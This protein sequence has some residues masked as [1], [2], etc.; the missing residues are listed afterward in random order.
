[1]PK[2]TFIVVLLALWFLPRTTLNA[3]DFTAEFEGP[4][5]S[6][7]V[8]LRAQDASLAIHQRRR[9]A[10]REGG[11]EVIRVNS[12]KENTPVRI[13]HPLPPATVLDELEVAVWVKSDREGFSLALKVILPEF[14][15][16]ET[17]APCTLIIVGDQYRTPGQWQQL[18]C[19]TK[20]RAVREQLQLKRALKQITRDPREMYVDQVILG[21][22]LPPGPTDVALDDL[23]VR[24]FVAYEKTLKATDPE[25]IQ[26]AGKSTDNPR[27]AVAAARIPV[28]FR[29]HRLSVEDRPFFPRMITYQN[30]RPEVLA[31]AGA[32]VVWVP[33]FEDSVVTGQLR[34]QGLWV[35]AA[36]PYAKGADGEALDSED[37]SLLPFGTNTSSVLFWM[38]GARMKLDGPPKL[39]S[40][41]NQIRD[42]DRGVRRPIAADVIE[43]ERLVSRH[44]DMLGVSRHVIHSIC[45]L[46]DYRDW[47][48]QRRE[49]A[50]PD[51]FCFTWIQTEPAPQVSDLARGVRTR[52]MLEPEQ[53]RLQ[54]YAALGAGCR[55]LGFWTT[56]PLD[57]D[58]PAARERLLALS[59]LNLELQLFE[60]WIASGG[61]PELVTFAIDTPRQQYSIGVRGIRPVTPPASPASR[62]RNAKILAA[63]QSRELKAAMIGSDRGALLLPMWLEE[64]SQFV[65]GPLAARNMSII[66]PG[67]GETAAAWEITTTGRL[68]N[69]NREPAAGGVKI[70]LP[71][72]DQTAAILLTSD[73]QLVAEL[74]EQI[75][76]IQDR[77]AYLCVELAK[78]K[79]AR[80]LEIDQTL[81]GMGVG[82]PEAPQLISDARQ[83]LDKAE[84]AMQAGNYFEAQ[85]HASE[86]LQFARLLQRNHWEY[87]IQ[88][89][90]N[91]TSSPWAVSFQSLP[92][93]WSLMRRIGQ[94]GSLDSEENLLPSGEFEDIKTLIG[95][96]WKHE[97]SML[98]TVQ[99]IAELH[100]VARQG[101]FSLR[102]AA[103]PLPGGPVPSV[104]SSAPV[105]VVSPSVTVHKGQFVKITG[106]VKIPATIV[107]SIE[108]ALIYD[109]LLGKSGAVRL[110]AAQDWRQF[111]LIRPVPES[112]D[113]SV[114]IA[115]QGLGEILLDDLRIVAV[116]LE[117]DYDVP[118]PA[119]PSLEPVK[120]S[121]LDLRRLNPL[122]RRK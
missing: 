119:V 95:E 114:T 23:S 5:N 61:K 9:G 46:A 99:S 64:N 48:I 30:E 16:P 40:W 50:W 15:D 4:E 112:Q 88:S 91:V 78:L 39:T 1:M 96:H 63:N 51:S 86:A 111:E 90:P 120:F 37:A 38:L 66:V 115:L 69:L 92:E 80:V 29:L 28:Q 32:N 56:T 108:G 25:S 68:R 106:W 54:V 94:L 74:N 42:A 24:P 77:S 58:S 55:G 21:G 2:L 11:A 93:H 98:E 72:L 8:R 76:S 70:S 71:R 59:Q 14:I 83:Q 75:A 105:T 34:R 103:S 31:D 102:L 18:K 57:E 35:T 6:W 22:Q 7:Q 100:H 82:R 122:Q 113:M 84:S 107:G 12:L 43:N 60:P 27:P 110:K 81:Q 10:G 117:A 45:S 79:M 104:I 85:Q 101:D 52:P 36:P 67:G 116:E 87:A 73:Q 65:P 19:Q 49:Q 17:N 53:I 20:E 109:S 44:V 13:E 118:S 47:M 33:D 41:T 26:Q 97:Q 89:M 3:G 62:A 121:P